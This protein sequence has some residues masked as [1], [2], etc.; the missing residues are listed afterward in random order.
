MPWS[1][2]PRSGSGPWELQ[3]YRAVR[4]L[5]QASG[6]PRIAGKDGAV[7]GGQG[8]GWPGASSPLLQ[9]RLIQKGLCPRYR[10]QGKDQ[11][12]GSSTLPS[13]VCKGNRLWLGGCLSPSLGKAQEHSQ[14]NPEKFVPCPQAPLQRPPAVQP[15]RIS[16]QH[17]EG[18]SREPFK[19]RGQCFLRTASSDLT[20]RL[21][22]WLAPPP[23]AFSFPSRLFSG[24]PGSGSR[25][26]SAATAGTEGGSRA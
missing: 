1:C 5:G 24:D 23:T 26:G 4:Q 10:Q 13:F 20:Q 8:G 2:V 3:L 18:G 6:R 17:A 21:L 7:Q 9:L 15:A 14:R 22:D 16:L 12:G 25:R 11:G 19:G